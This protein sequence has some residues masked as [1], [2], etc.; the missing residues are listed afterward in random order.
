MK[1]LYAALGS[2]FAALLAAVPVRADAIAMPLE[3]S[4]DKL[5]LVLV[6]LAAAVILIAAALIVRAV[7]K[8]KNGDK[9]K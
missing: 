8:R 5:N 1:K 9:K 7:L 4:E 2:L 3:T 6:V